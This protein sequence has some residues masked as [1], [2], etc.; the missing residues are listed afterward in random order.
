MV[1]TPYRRQ[2][3]RLRDAMRQC[4]VDALGP[5]GAAPVENES[6]D[7]GWRATLTRSDGV[8]AECFMVLFDMSQNSGRLMVD[9]LVKDGVHITHPWNTDRP[10]S[11]RP[12]AAAVVDPQPVLDYSDDAGFDQSLAAIQTVC[13]NLPGVISQWMNV[14]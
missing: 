4:M 11:L 12:E 13:Q 9:M 14:E 10:N 7:Y 1:E 2:Y 5:F 8:Q 6:E 3:K